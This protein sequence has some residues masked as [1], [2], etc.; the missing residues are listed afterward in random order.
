MFYNGNGALVQKATHPFNSD[1]H[2]CQQMAALKLYYVFSFGSLEPFL[3]EDTNG[4]VAYYFYCQ[5]IAI[6]GPFGLGP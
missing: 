2:T 6:H 5:G 1:K 4:N 3:F